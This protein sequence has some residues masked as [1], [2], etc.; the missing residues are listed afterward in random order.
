MDEAK[1]QGK[2]M[3]SE[4]GEV[5]ALIKDEIDY[6]RICPKSALT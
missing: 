1:G 6:L 5:D 3:K 4:S 2:A